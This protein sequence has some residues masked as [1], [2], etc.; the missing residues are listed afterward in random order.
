M[1]ERLTKRVIGRPKRSA[2]LKAT[3]GAR[4]Y[5]GGDTFTMG[6]IS[7]RLRGLAVDDVTD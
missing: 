5:L 1:S 7:A 4:P 2:L 3:W 6:D